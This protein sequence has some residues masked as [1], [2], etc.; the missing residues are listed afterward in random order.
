MNIRDMI[1]KLTSILK[2][3]KDNNRIGKDYNITIT[4]QQSTTTCNIVFY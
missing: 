2:T 3:K 4:V 1:L